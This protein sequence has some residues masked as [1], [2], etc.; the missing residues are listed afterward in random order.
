[1]IDTRIK[2]VVQFHY[3]LHGFHTGRGKWSSIMKLKL[4]QELAT[5][6]Q[7][8]L[9]LLLLDLRKAYNNLHRGRQLQKL[10][11]YEAGLKLLYLQVEFWSCQEVVTFQNGFH[12]PQFRTTIGKH[13]GEW[14]LLH[15]SM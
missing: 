15:S 4:A 10:A 1:M 14:P 13:R 6:Y 3:V 8:P 9:F 5:V 2:T 11:G 7:D 12:G